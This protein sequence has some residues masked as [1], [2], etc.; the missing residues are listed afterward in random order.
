MRPWTTFVSVAVLALGLGACSLP[1]LPDFSGE[2]EAEP[3][4]PLP[5]QLGLQPMAFQQLPGW[6]E[7][8]LAG[9]LNAFLRSCDRM[10]KQNFEQPVGGRNSPTLGGLAGRIVDWLPACAAARGNVGETPAIIRYFFES[11]FQ[12]Y[13]VTDNGQP[14]GLFT[15]YYEAELRGHWNPTERYRFP[16]YSRPRDLITVSLGNFK[17]DLKGQS[18][19]GRV[20]GSRL[21][22][23][24]SRQQIDQGYLDKRALEILYVD[25]PVDSFFLHVQGSG[26]VL[27]EDGTVVSLGYAGKNGLAYTSIGR[28]LIE[29]GALQR[30]EVSMSTIRAWLFDNPDRMSELL[31]ANESYVFFQQKDT[32]D[33]VGAE[34]VP[35][36]PGR[37]IAVDR[38]LIPYGVPIW[39]DTTDPL[40]PALP[41]RRL[42]I[43]QDTGGAIRG[44]VRGDLFW[45]YGE[46]AEQRAG[47]MKSRGSY[48]L[49]LPKDLRRIATGS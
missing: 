11:W 21:V 40:V 16:I 18:V 33:P 30:E 28:K 32:G 36:T 39:L 35:L 34:G 48:Y 13:L 42:L 22:P 43:A 8:D 19:H 2:P 12:P 38:S 44:A 46:E 27:M 29:M 3:A 7:D 23:Y 41:L 5:P 17:G 10:Q 25:D 47:E 49:L 24:A 4:E 9:A 37:S 15:G 31:W 20:Q 1:Q 26:R 45:G 6:K 14:E